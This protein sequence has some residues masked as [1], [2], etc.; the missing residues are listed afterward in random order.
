MSLGSGAMPTLRFVLNGVQAVSVCPADRRLAQILRDEHG[1]TSARMACGIGRCG[2]CM[3]LWNGRPVNAC[4][5]MA[6]QI[7]GAQIVTAEGLDTI[8]QARIV[9]TALA[10]ENAFQCGY[11]AP[12]FLV[13]LT[14]LLCERARVGEPDIRRALEGNICRCTGYHSIIRGALRAAEMLAEQPAMTF[15]CRRNCNAN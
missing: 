9:K 6:W 3:V 14:A 8:P 10:E 15:Q 4:L 1:L 5:V 13:T 11:C 2:A 12:G 7:D